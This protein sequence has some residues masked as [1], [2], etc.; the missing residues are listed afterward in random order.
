MMPHYYNRDYYATPENLDNTEFPYTQA[1]LD[2]VSGPLL[3]RLSEN[4]TKYD[5]GKYILSKP[6]SPHRHKMT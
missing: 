4:G 1:N 3:P 2:R 6:W 5:T